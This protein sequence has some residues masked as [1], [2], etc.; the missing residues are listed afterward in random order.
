LLPFFSFVF[1]LETEISGFNR[2]K[3]SEKPVG[4]LED[5]K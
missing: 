5:R 1:T 3:K 4:I 2:K